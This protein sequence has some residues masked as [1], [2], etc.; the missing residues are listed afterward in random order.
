MVDKALEDLDT[1]AWHVPKTGN[2]FSVTRAL[3]EWSL[4]SATEK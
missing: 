3:G 2:N 1:K 4:R